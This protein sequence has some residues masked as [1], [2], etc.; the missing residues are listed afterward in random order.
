MTAKVWQLALDPTSKMVLLRLADYVNRE[1]TTA[2]P[3]VAL[4]AHE[5]CIDER[6]VQRALKKLRELALIVAARPSLG[7]RSVVYSLHPERGDRLPPFVS[8]HTPAEDPGEPR[9][10]V[11]QTPAEDPEYPGTASPKPERTGRGKRKQEPRPPNP[12]LSRG[13]QRAL[14]GSRRQRD[15]DA[16]DREGRPSDY[17]FGGKHGRVLKAQ[18]DAQLEEDAG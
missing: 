8:P 10:T 5:C 2:W 17:Y 7:Y 13:A 3:S 9:H 4:L 18:L 14:D 1:G 16:L 15:R 12:P 6:T 11:V